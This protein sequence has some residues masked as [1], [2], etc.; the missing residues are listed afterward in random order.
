MNGSRTAQTRRA[1]TG[2]ALV[3]GRT[4]TGSA[5]LEVD[6]HGRVAARSCTV[7]TRRVDDVDGR[8]THPTCDP[9]PTPEMA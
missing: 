7:C 6:E 8:R 1:I 4:P 9:T 2:R 5:G 3:D